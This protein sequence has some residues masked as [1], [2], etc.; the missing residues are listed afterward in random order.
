MQTIQGNRT[1]NLTGGPTV[2]TERML[3]PDRDIRFERGAP[4]YA[5]DGRVGAVRQVVIDD[6]KLEVVALVIELESSAQ[7]VFISP[8]LVEKTGGSAIFLSANRQRFQALIAQSPAYR[9]DR[10]KK[11]KLK[12]FLRKRAESTANRPRR[13]IIEAGRD[14]IETPAASRSGERLAPVTSIAEGAA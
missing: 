8:D 1:L 9:R 11:V 2:P 14:F 3:R 5:T 6:T 12:S 13:S 10:F 4:V 7:R